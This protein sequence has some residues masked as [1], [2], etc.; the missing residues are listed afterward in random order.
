[1]RYFSLIPIL[2]ARTLP[3]SST[4]TSLQSHII[5]FSS[6][7]RINPLYTL[8]ISTKSAIFSVLILLRK[9]PLWVTNQ[10]H[11]KYTKRTS[12][13]LELYINSHIKWWIVGYSL[14]YWT[15]VYSLSLK[16]TYLSSASSLH[17]P[18]SNNLIKNRSSTFA[19]S[20]AKISC[21]NWILSCLRSNLLLAERNTLLSAPNAPASKIV[22]PHAAFP[23]YFI[24]LYL[25]SVTA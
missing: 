13:L 16:K 17:K 11:A 8:W 3:N 15:S 10:A 5:S 7:K 1:M 6:K 25:S 19:I 21:N 20:F 24:I 22:L 4:F 14:I 2:A 23:W 18:L 9:C 12:C